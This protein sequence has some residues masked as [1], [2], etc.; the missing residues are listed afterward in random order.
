MAGPLLTTYE[1]DV[2]KGLNS[3]NPFNSYLHWRCEK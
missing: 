2:F 1:P 3:D